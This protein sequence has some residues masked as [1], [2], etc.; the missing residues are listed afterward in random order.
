MKKK[1]IAVFT[2]LL[3]V[4]LAC[5]SLVACGDKGIEGSWRCDVESSKTHIY[6]EVKGETLKWMSKHGTESSTTELKY[7]LSSVEG[8]D[9]CYQAVR[10]D[11]TSYIV[12]TNND[13]LLW[14]DSLDIDSSTASRVF[15]RTKQSYNEWQK[16]IV[17]G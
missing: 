9:K 6:I 16:E 5:V 14:G 17:F 15:T 10:G 7:T 11:V 12:L 2:S 4:V 8:H 13:Q 3:L 1:L